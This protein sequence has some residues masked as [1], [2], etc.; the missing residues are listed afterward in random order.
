MDII[1]FFDIAIPIQEKT[2]MNKKGT[3][4]NNNNFFALSFSLS[5]SIYTFPYV[6][7]PFK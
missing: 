6:L 4:R 7:S 1:P 5:K 2:M 3:S